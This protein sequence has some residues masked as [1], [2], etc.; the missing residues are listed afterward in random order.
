MGHDAVPLTMGMKKTHVNRL[1]DLEP[2]E[3]LLASRPRPCILYKY[4]YFCFRLAATS[5]PV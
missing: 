4:H 2:G 3:L 5:G 1:K